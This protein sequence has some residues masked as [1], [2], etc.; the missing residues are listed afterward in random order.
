MMGSNYITERLLDS[1]R[2]VFDKALALPDRLS[3]AEQ[4]RLK[5]DV[6]YIIDHDVP[7][8]LKWYDLYLAEM[9]YSRSA[10]QNRGLYWSALGQYDKALGELQEAVNL[11]PFG[12][13]LI[14]P[15]LLNLGAIQVVLGRNDEA[16]QTARNLTG[17]F[18]GYL[19]IMLA[20]AE[21][22]WSDADSLARAALATPGLEGVFRINAATSLAS[23]R[24]AQGSVATADSVL[25]ASAV[26][27]K[28]SAARWYERARLLLQ[29]A[30]TRGARPRD[31]I[32]PAD[33]TVAAQMLRALWSA[34]SGDTAAA[35]STLNGTRKLSQR[36]VAMVGSAP[37]LIEA[38]I[39]TH[40]KRWREVTDRL[41]KIALDGEQDPTM[42]DRP[43]SFLQ[44]WVVANAYQSLGK[45]DSAAVYVQLMLRPT[46]L[47]PGHFALRGLSYDFARKRLTELTARQVTSNTTR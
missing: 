20:S 11:N 3:R 44:R 37:P 33:T 14:Q 9:P 5:G 31:N 25:G 7:A 23:A 24:A 34:A 17:P 30:Q 29:I 15:T 12:P 4:Y 38:L 8:A 10:R 28:G 40:G 39:A 32:V 21:S 43:D 22:R 46:H 47:P 27:S 41:G 35:R 1:A 16:R 19:G 13:G 45:P 36:D 2:Y 42:L 18:A 26:S 6:A